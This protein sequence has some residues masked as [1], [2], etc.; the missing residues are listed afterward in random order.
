MLYEVITVELFVEEPR[1]A[2]DAAA[3]FT[4]SEPVVSEAEPAEVDQPEEPADSME[5]SASSAPA[6]MDESVPEPV[7]EP[8]IEQIEVDQPARRARGRSC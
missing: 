2:Q 1:G 3:N 7:A 4:Q 5:A 6:P 8:V